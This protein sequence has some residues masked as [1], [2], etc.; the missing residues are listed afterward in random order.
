ML[1]R[2]VGP[3][4]VER[5]RWRA[6]YFRRRTRIRNLSSRYSRQTRCDSPASPHA[7]AT[8]RSAERQTVV[9]HG[10]DRESAFATPIDPWPDSAD[11]M[12]PD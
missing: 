7:V 5:P 4:G 2:S 8:P 12:L 3:T 11:T 10:P 9:A 6:M 1:E